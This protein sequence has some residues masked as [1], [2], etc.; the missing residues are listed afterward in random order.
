MTT[1]QLRSATELIQQV[2]TTRGLDPEMIIHPS[3]K[4]ELCE[5][6]REVFAI[7]DAKGWPSHKIAEL[8][9]RPDGRPMHSSNVRHGIRR[10]KEMDFRQQEQTTV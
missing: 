3:R 5:A 4:H 10:R 9:K 2:A 7:L 8:F 6:R 1:N